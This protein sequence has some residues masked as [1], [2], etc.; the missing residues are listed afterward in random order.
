[1]LSALLMLASCG[2]LPD[3]V[4]VS[5]FSSE[6]DFLGGDDLK[7]LGSEDG[8]STGAMVTATYKL[9]PTQIQI[10]QQPIP[11]IQIPKNLDAQGLLETARA[12]A[13]KAVKG[14]TKDF[15]QFS[16]QK[17]EDLLGVPISSFTSGSLLI[18][19]ILLLLVLLL[20]RKN[21][22]TKPE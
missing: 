16:I 9:K 12:E 14:A 18:V 1:M 5:G 21:H 6:Y 19:V 2:A 7:G 22:S 20:R 11:P 4:S 13:D 17:I 8:T 15:E 3:E 10:V